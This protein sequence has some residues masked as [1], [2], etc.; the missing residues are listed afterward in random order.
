MMQY[1]WQGIDTTMY[2]SAVGNA[3]ADSCAFAGV[4]FG[5][6]LA[7]QSPCLG[8]FAF[9]AANLNNSLTLR[10][11]FT[12]S[13]D[14]S[15]FAVYAP[16]KLS[17]QCGDLSF[18][19]YSQIWVAPGLQELYYY[20][21]TGLRKAADSLFNQAQPL[22]I[23]ARVHIS[24]SQSCASDRVVSGEPVFKTSNQFAVTGDGFSTTPFSAT[25]T[26]TATLDA[27]DFGTFSY[28][29]TNCNGCSDPSK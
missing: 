10:G 23:Y 24:G 8:E 28:R 16:A 4:A 27:F 22:G 13:I 14:S 20:N 15:G 29:L 17:G 21:K 25:V 7:G 5:S 2:F 9:A 18:D 12:K 19:G 26:A 1:S 3:G 6:P 11:L